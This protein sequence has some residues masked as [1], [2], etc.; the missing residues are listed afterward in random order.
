[1]GVS[2]S[3]FWSGAER[4]CS[5]WAGRRCMGRRLEENTKRSEKG[6]RGQGLHIWLSGCHPRIRKEL[7]RYQTNGGR[8]RKRRRY[9]IQVDGGAEGG[10]VSGGSLYHRIGHSHSGVASS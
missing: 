9:C 7:P 5:S 10:K 1:M 4:H 6:G 3:S 8:R 2:L